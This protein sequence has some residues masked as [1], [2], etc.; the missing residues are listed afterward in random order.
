MTFGKSWKFRN[1]LC[2]TYRRFVQASGSLLHAAALATE[3]SRLLV[4]RTG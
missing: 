3:A 1:L 2:T 4:S